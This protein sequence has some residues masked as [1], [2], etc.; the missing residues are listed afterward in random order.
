MTK[1]T[2]RCEQADDQHG[3]GDDFH[4]AGEARQRQVLVARHGWDREADQ[5]LQA[6][7]HEHE[8]RGDPQEGESPG[9][10]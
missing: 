3:A 7:L 2:G 1:L 4:D 10:V 8:G 6:M 9:F 5:F